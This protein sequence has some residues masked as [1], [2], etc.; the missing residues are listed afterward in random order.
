[1]LES[2]RSFFSLNNLNGSR[3]SILGGNR[4]RHA[5]NIEENMVGCEPKDLQ[6]GLSTEITRSNPRRAGVDGQH[7]IVTQGISFIEEHALPL[8][9]GD[10]FGCWAIE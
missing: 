9:R 7:I 5:Q 4:E 3:A 1:M 2:I 8:T 6:N 10:R